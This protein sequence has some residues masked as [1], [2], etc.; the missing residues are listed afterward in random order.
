MLR[1]SVSE[2]MYVMLTYSAVKV[3]PLPRFP[4]NRCFLSPAVF[5]ARMDIWLTQHIVT[6]YGWVA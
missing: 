3:P 1:I 5:D 6:C 2:R 4:H